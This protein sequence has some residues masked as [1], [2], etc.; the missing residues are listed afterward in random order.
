[1]AVALSSILP[2]SRAPVPVAQVL[3]VD[4]SVVARSVLGR[5]VDGT[6]R[7]RVA[8]ALSDVKAA[9]AFLENHRVDIVLLDIN[10][11]DIDGL[12]ALPDVL[13]AGQGAKVLIVSSSADEGAAVTVQALAL[14]AADTLVKPGIGTFGGRFAEV[15]E[16]RLSRLIEAVAEPV[17]QAPKSVGPVAAPHDF[18]VVAIGA[19]T[20]GIHALSQ[21]LRAIP[22]SFQVPILVTQ[23][24]PISFMGYFAAQLAVL[25]SRP[26]EV[27]TDRMRLRPG[28]IIVAPGNA[29]MR[30]A[31]MSEGWAVRLSDERSLSGCMPSVDPMFESVAEAFGKRALGVV[32]SGMGR[33]GAE[34]ARHLV[35]AGGRILVQDRESSV[36]WGMPGAVANAGHASAVLPPD[37]LGR[38][39]ARQGKA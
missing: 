22:Q 16:D 12:T 35:E 29:H 5:M 4:D 26:C 33:D 32:L 13:A 1:V 39:V 2:D 9:L 21:F 18:D 27:A 20:G 15:L 23:H 10:M 36:I 24:L 28:R 37:E 14:G 3:I 8:A 25:G 30:V 31:R 7:F 17:P 38:L 19:S 11:P 34:G 6:R